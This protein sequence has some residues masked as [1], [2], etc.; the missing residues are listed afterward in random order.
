MTNIHASALGS[1][2]SKRKSEASRENGKKGGR[3]KKPMEVPLTQG[4]VALVD[5]E[6][7]EELIKYKWSAYKT[8]NTFYAIRNIYIGTKRTTVNMH[9]VIIEP[10]NDLFVD[11]IDGNGLNNQRSNLRICTSSQNG[12][13]RG[14]QK[15][16]TSG[17]KG[18]TFC[19]NNNKWQAQIKVNKV[20]L[21]LGYFDTPEEAYKAYC[22]GCIK[23][24]GEFANF[25]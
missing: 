14:K 11:H 25:G 16:N 23:Y 22:E 17:F 5:R 1:I 15:V 8:N 9:R 13:N 10:P 3:P 7:Y 21:F 6:D 20:N 24:H 18:V 4:Y 12:M 19:K 2:K